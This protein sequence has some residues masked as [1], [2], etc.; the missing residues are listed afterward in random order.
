MINNRELQDVFDAAYEKATLSN[1]YDEVLGLAKQYRD[2]RERIYLGA[3]DGYP[4]IALCN[5]CITDGNLDLLRLVIEGGH[6]SADA[7]LLGNERFRTL[8]S[9]AARK[10]QLDIVRYLL[11]K[12]AN[13]N[14]HPASR[15]SPLFLAIT[16]SVSEETIQQS[17]EIIRVLIDHGADVNRMSVGRT[18]LDQAR[19]WGRSHA[20]ELLIAHGA[21]GELIEGQD[22]SLIP[23]NGILWHVEEKA[24]HVMP[25]CLRSPEMPEHVVFRQA[26]IKDKYRLLFTHGLFKHTKPHLELLACLPARWPVHQETLTGDCPLSFPEQAIARLVRSGKQIHHGLLFE[27]HSNEFMDLPWPEGVEGLA[28]LD[29]QWPTIEPEENEE[30]KEV[31]LM[32]VLPLDASRL[33][34]MQSKNAA[35]WLEKMRHARWNQVS[36]PL[37]V[38]LEGQTA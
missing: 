36:F 22:W 19:Y 23:G 20:A 6:C 32:L 28:I 7:T 14:G 15:Y 2:S 33:K 8:L 29:H 31:T 35:A 16:A 1:R 13:V 4:V 9:A 38:E 3:A 10:H 11:Q 27:R 30:E 17:D 5:L 18:P 25:V 24:G 21:V 34:K 37:P 12:G 26:I